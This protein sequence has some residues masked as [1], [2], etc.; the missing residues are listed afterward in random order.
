V[1]RVVNTGKR[2][3]APAVTAGVVLFLGGVAAI[4]AAVVD[5]GVGGGHPIALAL[6][7]VTLMLIGF[8]LALYFG[9]PM[10]LTTE[11]LYG[12]LVVGALAML[13]AGA[14]VMLA[15][16]AVTGVINAIVEATAGVSTTAAS[17][18]DDPSDLSRGEQLFRA[19]LQWGSG[20]VSLVAI[21]RVLPR[22]GIG[23]LEA[24]GG[25]A[26]RA[27]SR[28]SPTTGGN[29][30]RLGLLYG[31]FTG[32]TAVAYLAAGMPAFDALNH[33]LTVA[34]TGGWS[35]RAGSI[36]AFDSAAIEWVSIAAMFCAG[37]SLPFVFQILRTGRVRLLWTGIEFRVYM[38]VAAGAWVALTLLGDDR[39]LEGI[40]S[41]GFA[42]TSAVSTTG[43]VASNPSEFG[44]QGAALLITVAAVGGMAASLTGGLRLARILVVF[45]VMKRELSRQLH[46]HLVKRVWV[47]RSTVG[48]GV[49]SRILGEVMLNIIVAA[50]GYL[51]LA[52]YG[53]KVFSAIGST[54]SLLATAG[55]AY[56][57]V[58]PETTLT[59]LEPTGRIVAAMLMLFGRIS[60][61]PVLAAIAV[62]TKPVRAW[63]RRSRS[64]ILRPVLGR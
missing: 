41:A 34:S 4:P 31:V 33:G 49:V 17:V 54:L 15:T 23:G 37:V 64:R 8:P 10:R 53:E 63:M 16:G 43:L 1:L 46:P 45:S 59:A 47:G 26:T 44:G 38:A 50:V 27:A 32:L 52:F 20:V 24:G 21:V 18:I 14:A 42:A 11:E 13:A 60:V 22:L 5:I 19:M 2:D 61:L 25:V 62:V 55:P 48:E 39:S 12:S 57:S 58:D 6:A 9:I 3:S 36:G 28:L 29:L 30:R 40:R 51:A 7:S 56:G 35:T